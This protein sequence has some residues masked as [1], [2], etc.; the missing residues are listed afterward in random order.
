VYFIFCDTLYYLISHSHPLWTLEPTWPIKTR[1]V[2]LFGEFIVFA[3][4]VLF[5][6]KVSL[7]PSV[8]GLVDS[9]VGVN[10]YRS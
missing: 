9:I 1:L 2:A 7:T 4:T 6:R 3:I 5:Y 8:L 10:L